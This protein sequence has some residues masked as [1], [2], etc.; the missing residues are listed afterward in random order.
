VEGEEKSAEED[1][2]GGPEFN[3]Q[4]Q[5]EKKDFRSDVQVLPFTFSSQ[6]NSFI[7]CQEQY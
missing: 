2:S 3:L 6:A 1:Y 7:K 4:D 5:Q